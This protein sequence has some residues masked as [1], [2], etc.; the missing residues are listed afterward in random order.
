MSRIVL[1]IF[2]DC[3]LCILAVF[4]ILPHQPAEALDDEMVPPGSIVVV[5]EWPPGRDA[6][7]DLWVQAPNDV[8]VGYSNK[9][10]LYFNLLRD[11]L[12][13][14]SD[15]TKL[16]MEYSFSRGQPAGEYR[17]NLHLY[18]NKGDQ[19][20]IPVHIEISLRIRNVQVTIFKRDVVLRQLGEEIT[21][22]RFTLDEKGAVIDQSLIPIRLRSFGASGGGRYPGG[23]VG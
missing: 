2:V 1:T 12:G 16:N 6:D 19:S 11:D 17:I 4:I 5:A 10:S 8:P 18:S 22:Q 7:V 20:P 3:I 9:G 13:T 14:N 23:Y 21:V 15:A